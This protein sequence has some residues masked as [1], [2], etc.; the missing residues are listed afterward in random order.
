MKFDLV[1]KSA[2]QLSITQNTYSIIEIQFELSMSASIIL[3]LWPCCFVVS[4]E[5]NFNIYFCSYASVKN[6]ANEGI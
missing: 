3:Q 1:T 5:T 2:A 4:C 6:D